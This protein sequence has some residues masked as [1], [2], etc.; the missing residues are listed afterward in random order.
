MIINGFAGEAI[1]TRK[2]A[3]L[4][5]IKS[6]Q[7]ASKDLI[8]NALKSK[9]G[10]RRLELAAPF[11]KR[12]FGINVRHNEKIILQFD[13]NLVPASI[14]LDRV[15]GIDFCFWFLGYIVAIDVTVN[16]NYIEQKLNKQQQ[17]NKLY[18]QIGIDKIAVCQVG[19]KGENNLKPLLK[20]IIRGAKVISLA[21]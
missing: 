20:Q 16:P 15:Y 10:R 1:F 14:I 13:W 17:L 11:L 2:I 5:T 12:E 4:P 21:A 6:Y 9:L 18:Q 7:I 8:K 19:A 3:Q